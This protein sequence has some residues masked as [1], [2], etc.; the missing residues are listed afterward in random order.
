MSKPI[1]F[2]S[3]SS[4]DKEQIL[5][6]RDKLD[7]VTGGVLNIFLS[8]D[9][10]SIPFGTN[11]VHKVEQ[12]LQDATLMF[13]FITDNSVQS[14]WIYFES[15]FA[16]SRGIN[17]IPIGLGVDISGIKAPLNLLQGFNV[18][19]ADSLNNII[20][21]INREFNYSIADGFDYSDYI[22]ILGKSATSPKNRIPFTNVVRK[23][24]YTILSQYTSEDGTRKI[25]DIQIIYDSIISYLDRSNIQYSHS[26]QYNYQKQIV[27]CIMV[28]G[29]RILY[30]R[31]KVS[32]SH[33]AEYKKPGYIR[34][35]L[36]TINFDSSFDTLINILKQLGEKSHY[37][38]LHFQYNVKCVSN[39]EDLSSILS[40]YPDE[41][42]PSKGT[43]GRYT[44]KPMDIQ[45]WIFDYNHS[46]SALEEKELVIAIPFSCD[47]INADMIED[48]ITEL[49]NVSVL[50]TTDNN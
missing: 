32:S 10:Q 14:D 12:G 35:T 25:N 9:G 46:S 44:I 36:S 8:S 17:V 21:I 29:I 34:F 13:V 7:K 2:F 3:H 48:F 15:G 20:A 24:E 18:D 41:F 33:G 40:M 27:D 22:E 45:F 28:N 11:W 47:K 23:A 5:A 16:Y 50:K 6:I 42:I 30:L 37:L 1:V 39:D 49:I 19:S 26:D 38:V 31:D 43:I 4:K